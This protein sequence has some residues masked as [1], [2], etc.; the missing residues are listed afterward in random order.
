MTISNIVES[1]LIEAIGVNETTP[2][3]D[4]KERTFNKGQLLR[5]DNY[6]YERVGDDL[7]AKD[8][9][10]DNTYNLNDVVWNNGQLEYISALTGEVAKQPE[11]YANIDTNLD[12]STWQSR[13]LKVGTFQ[14]VYN[15]MK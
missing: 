10:P 13:Y 12:A 14:N 9:N 1:E 11:E 7:Y 4:N 3:F 5:Q 8:F 15:I 6:I 2:I